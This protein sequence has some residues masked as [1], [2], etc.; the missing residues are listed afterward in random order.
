[1]AARAMRTNTPFP[2]HTYSRRTI[3]RGSY[4]YKGWQP[5]NT[6]DSYDIRGR[7]GAG[8]EG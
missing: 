1:M 4:D 3:Y 5:D 7:S 6:K 8:E 2:A